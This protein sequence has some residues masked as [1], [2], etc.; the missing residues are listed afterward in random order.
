VVEA[1]KL[2]AEAEE[3]VRVAAAKAAYAAYILGKLF[4]AENRRPGAHI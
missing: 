3:V 4:P 2:L 1:A